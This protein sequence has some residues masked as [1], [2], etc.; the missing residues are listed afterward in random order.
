MPVGGPIPTQT[1]QW[2]YRVWK[3]LVLLDLVEDQ[4]QDTHSLA[5]ASEEAQL[6]EDDPVANVG[7]HQQELRTRQQREG[8]FHKSPATLTFST[9][10]RRFPLKCGLDV[11]SPPLPPPSPISWP[12]STCL[13]SLS[14]ST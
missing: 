8:A 11:V 12:S 4:T 5:T 1:P 14:G 3:L 9:A 6:H 13:S 2:Y 10:V 7:R